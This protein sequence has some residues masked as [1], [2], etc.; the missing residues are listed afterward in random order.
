MG[1]DAADASGCD[2]LKA[3]K[4]F[5][6][7]KDNN[8][9]VLGYFFVF[10]FAAVMLVF[11]FAFASPFLIAFSTDLYTAGDDIITKTESKLDNITNTTIRNMIQNNLDEMQLN[12]AYNIQYLSFFYTYAWIFII[13]VV[14]F[15]IF[16]M[17]RKIV[18]TRGY[19]GV[20]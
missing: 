8:E 7:L 13:L 16:I 5:R 12:T 18:E 15:T 2:F 20:V 10:L 3:N 17:A 6:S 1:T 19:T 14:T 11:L 9:A 4:K